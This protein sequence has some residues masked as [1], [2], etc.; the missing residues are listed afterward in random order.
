MKVDSRLAFLI[1]GLMVLVSGC[2][3][4]ESIPKAESAQTIRTAIAGIPDGVVAVDVLGRSLVRDSAVDDP[5][6]RTSAILDGL[7]NFALEM[8]GVNR[9]QNS[10]DT[11][12]AKHEWDGLEIFGITI[13][14]NGIVM[15]DS[16]SVSIHHLESEN[17]KQYRWKSENMS[18]VEPGTE[19]SLNFELLVESLK[20]R[21]IE[22]KGGRQAASGIWQESLSIRQ[23]SN[24]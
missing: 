2:S 5:R 13:Y 1:V 15:V 3:R 23:W 12:I 4:L 24:E 22:V 18:L 6:I 16:V 20:A 10:N 17:L 11:V 8:S 21:G 14:R 9:P 7:R 19:T